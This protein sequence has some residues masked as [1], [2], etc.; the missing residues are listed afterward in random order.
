MNN[1]DR[2]FTGKRPPVFGATRWDIVRGEAKQIVGKLLN[3]L[4]APGFVVPMKIHDS[5]TN[6]QIEV[7]LSGFFTVISIDGRDYYFKRLSGRYDGSGMALSQYK[8]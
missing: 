4:G 5:L 3:G 7:R 8:G 2:Y 6:T 1:I